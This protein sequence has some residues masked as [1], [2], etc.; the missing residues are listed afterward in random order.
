MLSVSIQKDARPRRGAVSRLI[1]LAIWSALLLM[2]FIVPNTGFLQ[3]MPS[4]A[5]PR[6]V[7]AVSSTGPDSGKDR[8]LQ[9]MTYNIRHAEGMDGRVN[10]QAV[11]RDLKAAN[12]DVI[13]L[14][15]VDRLQ[16]RSGLQ[17][18]A[19]YFAQ[20]MGMH[21]IYAPALHRG[22]SQ[23]G[24][25]LLS[26]YPLEAPQIHRLTGG[27]EPRL[28][29]T[30][31]LRLPDRT[32]TVATTH[33]SVEDAGRTREWP[34]L[35]AALQNGQT[36]LI[37]LG[38]F[39]SSSSSPELQEAV[40]GLGLKEIRPKPSSL[41]TVAHGGRIDHIFTNLQAERPA[42]VGDSRASDHRPVSASLNENEIPLHAH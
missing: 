25:A 39:N 11:L 38:D 6:P 13:A 7:P 26:R 1:W 12:A 40:R 16:W 21:C 37:L 34:Q 14:Q 36:P 28:L 42:L 5:K 17:D 24:V 23:Y 30:A 2:A 15:E 9:V 32:V 8:P 41:P 18:Q 19:R 33:L 22:V 29:L 27:R 4:G 20:A 31:E 3:T 35:L 10:P